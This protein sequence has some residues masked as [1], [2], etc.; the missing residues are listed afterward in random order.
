M[1]NW[2][3]LTSFCR[4]HACSGPADYHR[5]KMSQMQGPNVAP[6][7]L[8]KQNLLL[9]IVRQLEK[10]YYVDG[11]TF[12]LGPCSHDSSTQRAN[13][14]VIIVRGTHSGNVGLEKVSIQYSMQW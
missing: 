10:N 13:A 14:T 12:R 6:F 2:G 5:V 7:T 1:H 8:G 9:H 3:L 11:Q 4:C